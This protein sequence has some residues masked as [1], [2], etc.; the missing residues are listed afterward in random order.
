[1]RLF[2]SSLNDSLTLISFRLRAAPLILKLLGFIFVA[3][4]FV[5]IAVSMQV[6]SLIRVIMGL[7]L[8]D[9]PSAETTIRMKEFISIYL[10]MYANNDMDTFVSIAVAFL[11]GSIIF[12]PFSGYVIHGVVSNS[13]MIIVKNGDNYKIGDSI[14]FQVISSFTLVQLLGLTVVSQLLTFDSEFGGFAT[15]FVWGV[16]VLMTLVTAFFSWVVE[17]VARRYGRKIRIL[18]LGFFILAVAAIFALDPNHGTTLFG[19]SKIIFDFIQQLATGDLRLL[20]ASLVVVAGLSVAFIY[21]LTLVASIT[22][23]LPEPMA[24]TKLN[25]KQ[26]RSLSTGPL[27]PFRLMSQLLFRYQAITKPVMTSLAF[28]IVIVILMGGTGGLSTVMIVLP[29]AVSVSFSA[30]IFGLVSGSMNWLLTIEGW[31]S[32]MLTAAT[33]LTV[34]WILAIYVIVVGIGF[35]VQSISL[36]DIVKLLPSFIATTAT[37]TVLSIWLSAKY[38]LPFSGKTRENLVSSPIRLMVYVALFLMISGTAANATYYAVGWYA[39]A[40]CAMFVGISGCCY[41]L[42]HRKWNKTDQYTAKILKET[43][44]AG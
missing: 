10:Q 23:R 27:S 37:T 24:V 22:L 31:R 36:E 9:D 1:M 35:A 8:A 12:V 41:F 4:C 14:M 19:S 5:F 26:V 43:I 17:Y 6:N 25:E 18:F 11:L 39:W 16:W 38:P 28:S 42:I 2:F 40:L 21:L 13:E 34:L 44:N 15:V 33:L 7:S 29:L 30:N 3:S 32:K 20:T